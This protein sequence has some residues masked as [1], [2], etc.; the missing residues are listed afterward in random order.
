MQVLITS[1]YTDG[2]LSESILK[3]RAANTFEELVDLLFVSAVIE[4]PSSCDNEIV[5]T[6]PNTD[7]ETMQIEI[8]NGYRE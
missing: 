6:F 5:V 4:S 7:R 3:V 8:V 1:T 2:R